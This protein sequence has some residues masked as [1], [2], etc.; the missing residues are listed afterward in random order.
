MQT[1]RNLFTRNF[2]LAFLAQFAFTSVLQLLF[3]TLPIYLKKLGSTEIE[4]G[5]LVGVLGLAS[6]ISR[7]LVGR[8]LMKAREKTFMIV[9]AVFYTL[10]SLAY[11]WIPPFWPLLL[12]RIVQGVGFGF[13]HTASTTYVVNGSEVGHR[14]RILGYFALSMNIAGVIAPPLG[15]VLVN[16]FG[17]THLFLVCTIVSSGMLFGSG[18][19]GPVR[20]PL[21]AGDA[22]SDGFLLS[23]RALPPSIISLM[24][25]FIWASLTTFFPLYATSRGVTNPGLF[26]TVMAIMLI[27][28]R[29]LGGRIMDVSNK[30]RVIYPSILICAVAMG[31][32]ALSRTQPLFLFVAALW[33][34]GHAFLIPSL[35]AFAL[36]RAGSSPSPVVATFYAVSDIGL[37]LGPLIMG[38]VARYTGY[39]TMFFCLSLIGISGLF[40]FWYFTRK[41]GKDLEDR[42]RISEL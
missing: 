32:L 20:K 25:I 19:L 37:F 11:I 16:R 35:M 8:A 27:L 9:G 12:V 39:P 36:E 13:F 7:P 14:A 3:P 10:S 4:I 21:P 6:L 23:R 38:I 34:T 17:F 29:T 30:K 1:P 26:F 42:R 41:D 15:I 28:S 31:L 18:L 40:Y 5:V 22:H 2:I 24:S 33:G